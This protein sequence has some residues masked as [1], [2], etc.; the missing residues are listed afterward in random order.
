MIIKN[1]K[2]LATCCYTGIWNDNAVN[3]TINQTSN[4]L[5]I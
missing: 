1:V 2:L 3:D 5:Y 4:M